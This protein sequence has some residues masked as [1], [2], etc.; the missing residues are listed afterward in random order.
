MKE[1]KIYYKK[2]KLRNPVLLVGL[3]GMGNVGSLVAAHLKNELKAKKFA[4]LLSPH[5]PYQVMMLKSGAFRELAGGESFGGNAGDLRGAVWTVVGLDGS[6]EEVG[7]PE[8]VSARAKARDAKR[9]AD[10]RQMQT[11]LALFYDSYGYYPSARDQSSCGGWGGRSSSA[12]TDCGGQQWLTSDTKFNAFMPNVPAD[13]INKKWYAE[14]GAYT[15]TYTGG[16]NDYDLRALLEVS[17]NPN[18]CEMK[19][20]RVHVMGGTAWCANHPV[21]NPC[22]G[23]PWWDNASQP[24][25]YADH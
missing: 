15:Y 21:G 19:C 13:P 4:T 25:L 1:T 5:F 9:I 7:L 6:I 22:G 11:A 12:V 18:R 24:M 8:K 23:T 14:D 10:L 20:Y 16:T 3:P 17:T 2:V